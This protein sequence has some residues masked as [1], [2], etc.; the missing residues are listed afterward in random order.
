MGGDSLLP[1]S[2]GTDAFLF[3]VGASVVGC[4][5][6]DNFGPSFTSVVPPIVTSVVSF[7]FPIDM[8]GGLLNATG[9]LTCS[10]CVV[11]AVKN[12]VFL[13]AVI[14]SFAIEVEA[15]DFRGQVPYQLALL[16]NCST[17][18]S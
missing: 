4:F 8:D 10:D 17:R 2:V 18:V 5:G 14:V 12:E 16:F 11:S 13:S 6:G 15:A 9:G 1:S 7:A 3:D